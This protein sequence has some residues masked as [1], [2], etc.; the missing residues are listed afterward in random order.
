MPENIQNEEGDVFELTSEDQAGIQQLF[1]VYGEAWS[2][3]DAAGCAALYAPDG[4]A[5]AI[6]GEVLTGPQDIE[7]YYEQHLSG[8][9]KDLTMSDFELAP[10]RAL[11]QDIALM[12]GSWQLTGFRTATGDPMPV[13]VRATFIMRKVGSE[14][15]YVA[16]RL[17]VPFRGRT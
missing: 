15:L 10:A 1:Q 16:V 3:G 6:D 17:M 13:K 12:D 4:D 8:K 5:F 11:G 2:S 14:W 7:A 9:Y